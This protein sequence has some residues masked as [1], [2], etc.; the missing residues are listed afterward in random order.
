MGQC[1]LHRGDDTVLAI[2][3]TDCLD[4]HLFAHEG[5]PTIRTDKQLGFNETARLQNRAHMTGLDLKCFDPV[6]CQKGN[7]RVCL[8]S[9]FQGHAQMPVFHH[10]AKRPIP[11]FSM[12]K[13]QKE[14]R[15]CLPRSP[16]RHNNIVDRL[17]MG[18][19]MRIK[20]QLA[21]HGE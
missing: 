2:I 10:R 14:R 11:N 3:P 9:R 16:V 6:R 13:M 15:R 17:K 1:M 5:R 8:D 21:E 12:I 20:P 18:G 19:Q 7:A 4:A